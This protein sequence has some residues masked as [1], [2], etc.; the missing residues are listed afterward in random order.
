MNPEALKDLR[1][2]DIAIAQGYVAR[3]QME[4]ALAIQKTVQERTQ[5]YMPI[6]RVMIQMQLLTQ[7]QVDNVFAIQQGVVEAPESAPEAEDELVQG[8][9]IEISSD[10]MSV[11]LEPNGKPRND[12]SVESVKALLERQGFVEPTC[13]DAELAAFL[14]QDPAAGEPLQAVVGT[15]PEAG[16]ADEIVYHFDTDPMRVGTLGEDGNIDW[17]DHGRIPQVA[18]GELLAEKIKGS[19][20]KPGKDVYGETIEPEHFE[21]ASLKSGKG[22]ELSEDGMQVVATIDGRPKLKSTGRIEVLGLM[23]IDGD[24]G[25]ETG[26]VEFGGMVEVK[27][28]IS[29]GYRVKCKELKANEIQAATIEVSGDLQAASGVYGSNLK[30]GGR[31]KAKHINNCVIDAGRD[32]LVQREI[33]DC[34]ID[35]GG[36]CKIDSGNLIASKISAKKGVMATDVGTAASRASQL[37]VGVDFQLS[38]DLKAIKAERVQLDE[39][40]AELETS[41]QESLLQS[42]QINDQLGEVAQV[43]DGY[44]VTRRDLMARLKK[45][46]ASLGVEEMGAMRK[47]VKD[48]GEK[49]RQIEQ[50]V[51][52][53]MEKD[54]QLLS[55]ASDAKAATL[56]VQEQIEEL[57]AKE[58]DLIAA[59][60]IDPG[61]PVVKVAGTIYA[62][63]EVICPHAKMVLQENLSRVRLLESAKGK[64]TKAGW[65]IMIAP[66]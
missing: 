22:C 63:T 18:T 32:V 53:M 64:E 10:K 39:R 4:R 15:A 45:E 3:D 20:G 62:K 1:F 65:H 26:H 6:G 66:F 35:S 51:E 24:V 13:D 59:A 54:D 2:G 57:E 56:L 28:A 49:I 29:S 33:I 58:R 36:C 14:E 31:V 44:M 34:T 23:V 37:T 43:Q 50:K 9:S 11:H 27:G 30:V 19:P 12:H 60:E 25:I 46:V 48:L 7:E 17:K 40:I 47:T 41:A 52:D 5:F 21:S 16:T 55:T 61:V 38:R 42:D 8:F